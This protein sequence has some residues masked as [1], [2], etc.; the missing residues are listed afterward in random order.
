[1]S[2]K[3]DVLEVAV[4]LSDNTS[5]ILSWLSNSVLEMKTFLFINADFLV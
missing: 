4:W 3:G 5:V 1:M 2:C